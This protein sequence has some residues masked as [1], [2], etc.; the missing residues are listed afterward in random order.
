[1][2]K[3]ANFVEIK[4]NYQN[5]EISPLLV[6]FGLTILNSIAL[7]EAYYSEGFGRILIAISFLIARVFSVSYVYDI[8][9]NLKLNKR[10]W[11]TLTIFFPIIGFCVVPFLGNGN[12]E[13]YGTIKFDPQRPTY[14]NPTTLTNAF[15]ILYLLLMLLGVIFTTH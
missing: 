13:L 14:T 4:R 6:G 12:S 8:V 3:E 9:T 7:T 2:L 15:F 10:F 1:M 11:V 5:R